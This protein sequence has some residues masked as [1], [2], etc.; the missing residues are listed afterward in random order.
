MTGDIAQ[1]ALNALSSA[2]PTELARALTTVQRA[3]QYHDQLFNALHNLLVYPSEPNRATA[4]ALLTR[5]REAV[6]ES[7]TS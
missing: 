1:R 3:V 6:Q 5:I 2:G 7:K 4:Y